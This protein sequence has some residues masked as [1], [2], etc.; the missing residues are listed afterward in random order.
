MKTARGIYHDLSQSE[1][2]VEYEDIVFYFSSK[3]YMNNF[4]DKSV[5]EIDSFNERANRVYKDKFKLDFSTLAL[6]RLYCL[7]EKRGFH[8][9]YKGSVITCL[10]NLIFELD[11]KIVKNSEN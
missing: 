5:C 3:L 7:I 8:I 4:F 11:L 10:E 6:I 9:V 2:F 1:Y